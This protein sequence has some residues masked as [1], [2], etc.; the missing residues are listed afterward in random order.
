MMGKKETLLYALFLSSERQPLRVD[1]RII[2]LSAWILCSLS[3]RR[4]D[5]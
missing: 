4:A 5:L 2:I 3:L 1:G